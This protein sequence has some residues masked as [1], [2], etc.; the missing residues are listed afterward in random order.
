[1][2]GRP[3][4][5]EVGGGGRSF[6]EIAGSRTGFFLRILCS[7]SGYFPESPVRDA[8][9]SGNL[10]VGPE[11]RDCVVGVPWGLSPPHPHERELPPPPRRIGRMPGH[12]LARAEGPTRRPSDSEQKRGG[13][14]SQ[15]DPLM[16]L[17]KNT[18]VKPSDSTGRGSGRLYRAIYKNTPK[19][20]PI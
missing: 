15:F 16:I 3:I 9:F 14:E 4:F 13:E 18:P 5:F 11:D 19:L 2:G 6:L 7:G 8:D 1:V 17:P 20:S 10:R 12:A